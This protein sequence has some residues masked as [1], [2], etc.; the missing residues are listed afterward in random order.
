MDLL[1]STV[2]LIPFMQIFLLLAITTALLLFK[3]VNLALM[4][5]YL[6]SFYWGLRVGIKDFNVFTWYN[7]LYLGFGLII[8]VL[9][10]SYFVI[11]K[12]KK[13]KFIDVI[14]SSILTFS[15]LNK[16]NSNLKRRTRIST[17]FYKMRLN[18]K[19]RGWA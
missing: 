7:F 3:R 15:I 4:A 11:Q 5:V 1:N 2:I 13:K 9:V 6:F 12:K 18:T 10:P 16:I 14:D 19:H 8:A 17:Y